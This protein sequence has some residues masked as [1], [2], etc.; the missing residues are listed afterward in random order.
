LLTGALPFGRDQGMPALLAHLSAPPPSLVSRKPDLPGAVDQVLARAMAKAPE[1][2]YDTCTEFAD[3]LREA[4]G[5]TPYHRRGPVSAPDHPQTEIGAPLAEIASPRP[6]FPV[7]AAAGAGAGT[8]AV[9]ED[10]AAA[11]TIDAGR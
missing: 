4:L 10:L 9:L 8:A 11:A 3:A 6:E 2:R 1:E 7:P 5:V